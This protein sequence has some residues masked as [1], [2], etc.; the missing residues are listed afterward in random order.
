MQK[1]GTGAQCK[2]SA[3]IHNYFAQLHS[4]KKQLLTLAKKQLF[5]LLILGDNCVNI[6]AIF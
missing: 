1:V 3:T 5:W 2:G 4:C 6:A